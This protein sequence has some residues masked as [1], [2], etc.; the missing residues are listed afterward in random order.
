M[1]NKPIIIFALFFVTLFSC[2]TKISDRIQPVYVDRPDVKEDTFQ[3]YKNVNIDLETVSDFDFADKKILILINSSESV[4]YGTYKELLKSKIPLP[5]PNEYSKN[6]S[7]YLVAVFIYDNHKKL[8]FK[9]ASD[10]SNY[11]SEKKLNLIKL[12]YTGIPEESVTLKVY[13]I[14]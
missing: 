9:W 7:G 2:T 6:K 12:L 5:K 8:I 1:T 11:F 14:E 4:F 3:V 10:E 13:Q